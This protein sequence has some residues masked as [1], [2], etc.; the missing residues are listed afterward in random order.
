MNIK[1]ALKLCHFDIL[2]NIGWLLNRRHVQ[3]STKA[4]ELLIHYCVNSF[5]CTCVYL[6]HE[7]HICTRLLSVLKN[8]LSIS[9]FSIFCFT[10]N[11]AILPVSEKF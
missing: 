6:F 5:M 11:I 3:F 1:L 2:S 7:S 9:H 4:S 8:F 10:A